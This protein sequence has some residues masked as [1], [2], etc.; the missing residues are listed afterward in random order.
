MRCC[1]KRARLSEQKGEFGF[2]TLELVEIIFVSCLFRCWQLIHVLESEQAM[3]L[4]LYPRCLVIDI[5]SK[6]CSQIV[7]KIICPQTHYTAKSGIPVVIDRLLTKY[8][9]PFNGK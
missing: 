8:R 9:Q 7:W 5:L 3:K 6:M 1:R 2:S 4:H